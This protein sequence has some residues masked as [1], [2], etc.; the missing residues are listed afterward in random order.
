MTC[1]KPFFSPKCR[2]FPPHSQG[3]EHIQSESKTKELLF[4]PA[5]AAGLGQHLWGS[6][7]RDLQRRETARTTFEVE[8]SKP[9]GPL[10]M[11]PAKKKNIPVKIGPGH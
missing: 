9:G 8:E 6:R 7:G 3:P 11:P 1:T 2:N 5:K 10:E 4:S